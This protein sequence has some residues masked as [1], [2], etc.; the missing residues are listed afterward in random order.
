MKKVSIWLSVLGALLCSTETA[1]AQNG[2]LFNRSS[3]AGSSQTVSYRPQEI[4]PNQ[5]NQITLQIQ[6][7]DF[8]L[9]L[10]TFHQ[11][12]LGRSDCTILLPCESM[13]REQL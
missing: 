10:P 11:V 12:K 6:L 5:S 1:F 9:D 3:M 2:S 7:M 8:K 4:A 13:K